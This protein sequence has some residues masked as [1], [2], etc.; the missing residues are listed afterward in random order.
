VIGKN[1]KIDFVLYDCLG[2][3]VDQRIIYA[4]RGVNRFDIDV[5]NYSSSLYTYS[6]FSS[7]NFL[8]K[9]IFVFNP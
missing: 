3:I 4:N 1:E 9:K 7:N 6:I 8:S 2:K 5:S